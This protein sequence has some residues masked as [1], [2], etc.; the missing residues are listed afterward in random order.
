MHRKIILFLTAASLVITGCDK[1]NTDLVKPLSSELF[2]QVIKLDDEGDGGL[3][4]E[5]KFS[6]KI[7]LN[8]RQDPTGEEIAGTVVPLNEEVRVFFELT[9]LEGFSTLSDYVRGATAFYEID[10]CTTSEDQ[11][12][13][14][15]V[16][17]DLATGKGSVLFPKAVTEIEIVFETDDSFFDDNTLNT[18]KRELAVS[19][20]GVRAPT[21]S[22]VVINPARKFTYTIQDNEAIH[23][24]W[25]LDHNNVDQFAAFKELFGLVNED[26]AALQASEVDKIEIAFEYDELK[27]KVT[28][29]ETETITECGQTEVVNKEIEVE[30]ELAALSTLSAD[31]E[32]EL[33][34]EIE[35]GDGSI[36]EFKYA[37]SFVI[38][39]SVLT[40]TLQGEYDDNTTSELVLLLN[41]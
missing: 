21:G 30:A 13:D 26:I 17:L 37:G 7:T 19:L 41:K 27:V 2:P 33:E 3:E 24:D 6:V 36:A 4:D 29:V 10:D 15:D 22:N 32:V 34:G 1:E 16:Q 23:G 35:Q 5:D 28:L 18:E 39:G 20:T 12:I 25:E 38:S 40:L 31:G 9:E 11:N 8:E 14:L